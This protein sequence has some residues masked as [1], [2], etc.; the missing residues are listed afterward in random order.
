MK[1]IDAWL[2]RTGMLES[3]LGLL[4]CANPYAVGRIRAGTARVETLNEVLNYIR[5]NPAQR[6]SRTK[7][8]GSSTS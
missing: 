7:D 8:G 5:R 2:K 1:A 4:A 6:S 3:R